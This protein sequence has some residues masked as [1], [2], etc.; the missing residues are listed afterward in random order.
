MQVFHASTPTIEES[1][2]CISSRIC[3][4]ETKLK[5]NLGV[6]SCSE[7]IVSMLGWFLHL[8]IAAKLGCSMLSDKGSQPS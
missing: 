1:N 8:T 2:I 6:F 3:S 5:E 7:V 4:F